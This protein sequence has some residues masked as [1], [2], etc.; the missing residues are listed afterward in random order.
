[1]AL[2]GFMWYKQCSTVPKIPIHTASIYI[3]VYVLA[4]MCKP[5]EAT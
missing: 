1:M 2:D 5:T 3:H 4:G